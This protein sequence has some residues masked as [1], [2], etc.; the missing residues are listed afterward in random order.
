MISGVAVVI[1]ANDILK[2][3]MSD[4]KKEGIP[5]DEEIKIGAMI[6]IPSAALYGGEMIALRKWTSSASVPTI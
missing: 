5:F 1:Q 6:E 3:V 4:L 2:Q